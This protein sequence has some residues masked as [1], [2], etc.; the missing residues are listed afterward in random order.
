[1]IWSN[2]SIGFFDGYLLCRY[3]PIV[4]PGST[5][6]IFPL[7]YIL[8][9]PFGTR[10]IIGFIS[11]KMYCSVPSSHSSCRGPCSEF[12]DHLPAKQTCRAFSLIS[13]WQ[14]VQSREGL[15]WFLVCWNQRTAYLMLVFRRFTVSPTVDHKCS[16]P[17]IRSP[18]PHWT[19]AFATQKIIISLSIFWS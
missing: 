5:L 13:Q 1:M 8:S 18:C 10:L 6:G 9:L 19:G 17:G 15:L 3:K 2:W 7:K 4:V 12:P 14:S 11:R 16:Q